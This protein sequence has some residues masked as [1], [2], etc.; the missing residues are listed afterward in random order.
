VEIRQAINT[1]RESNERRMLAD[2]KTI[3]A[4]IDTK[5]SREK[6]ENSSPLSRRLNVARLARFENRNNYRHAQ[7]RRCV[8][9]RS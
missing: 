4:M 2:W 1:D 7:L 3:M 9:V 8:P 5:V 6:A